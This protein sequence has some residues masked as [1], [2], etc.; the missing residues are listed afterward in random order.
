MT[1]LS[2]QMYG[3][4]KTLATNLNAVF[5][6][7]IAPALNS[8]VI[9]TKDYIFDLFG[10]Y[11]Q[12]AIVRDI[13]VILFVVSIFAILPF[14][15]KKVQAY[16]D[17]CHP[18]NQGMSTSFFIAFAVCVVISWSY[19]LSHTTEHLVQSIFIPELTIYEKIVDLK[20]SKP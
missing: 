14:R 4:L 11:I 13:I 18:A 3:D 6:E 17:T 16:D 1:G 5:I 9:I 10:R 15:W 20:Q 8:G 12:Y 19:A 7:K 2:A